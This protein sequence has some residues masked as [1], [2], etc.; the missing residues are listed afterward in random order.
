MEV[1]EC[2]RLLGDS[3]TVWQDIGAWLASLLRV[4]SQL[5]SEAKAHPDAGTHAGADGGCSGQIPPG[6]WQANEPGRV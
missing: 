2:L 4:P 1:M 3:R 6:R 5:T